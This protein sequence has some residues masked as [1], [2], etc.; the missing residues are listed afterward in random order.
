MGRRPG[1][2]VQQP[3]DGEIRDPFRLA[4]EQSQ[5]RRKLETI[6]MIASTCAL[7]VMTAVFYSLLSR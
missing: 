2:D 5:R 7:A 1:P 3:L 6:A 4:E